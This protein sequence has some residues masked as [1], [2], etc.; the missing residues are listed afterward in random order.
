[1]R[2]AASVTW[3]SWIAVCMSLIYCIYSSCQSWAMTVHLHSHGSQ[4]LV[5]RPLM[6]SNPN[7]AQISQAAACSILLQ[8]IDSLIQRPSL[9]LGKLKA[10][11]IRHS[12]YQEISFSADPRF[13]S[14]T[15]LCQLSWLSADQLELAYCCPWQA[16][17]CKQKLLYQQVSHMGSNKAMLDES[18][19][20]VTQHTSRSSLCIIHL[21]LSAVIA[22]SW[23]ACACMVLSLASSFSACSCRACSCDLLRRRFRKLATVPSEGLLHSCR[24]TNIFY[25]WK[26][27]PTFFGNDLQSMTLSAHNFICRSNDRI[28]KNVC[29]PEWRSSE[30]QNAVLL[31]AVLIAEH[32]ISEHELFHLI[33]FLP[34]AVSCRLQTWRGRVAQQ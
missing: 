25:Q 8:G 26:R 19:Q 14:S 18:V 17:Q 16:V 28:H 32:L 3:P 27:E 11:M 2:C 31:N 10:C 15:C 5:S 22:F 30:F 24:R 1:M 23:S 4:I 29:C 21:S 7:A 20:S 34:V 12:Q 9:F 13:A 33:M 6:E